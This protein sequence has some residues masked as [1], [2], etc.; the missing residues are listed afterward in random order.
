M[1]VRAKFTLRDKRLTAWGSWEFNFQTMYDQSIPEDQKFQKATPSGF[2]TMQVDN[3]AVLDSF[4]VGKA[5]Y[6]DFEQVPTS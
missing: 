4:E 3:P 6:I 5:Y 1:K 2:C